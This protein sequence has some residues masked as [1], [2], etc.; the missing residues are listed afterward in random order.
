MQQ[1]KD[2]TPSVCGGGG[3]SGAAGYKRRPNNDEENRCFLR[4]DKGSVIK[5][6]S[7]FISS[8]LRRPV[9]FLKGRH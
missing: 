8:G 5:E 6:L 4:S 9:C 3:W 7:L 2:I 1:W